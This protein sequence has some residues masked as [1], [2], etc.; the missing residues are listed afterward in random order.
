[1]RAINESNEPLRCPAAQEPLLEPCL[2]TNNPKELQERGSTK[3]FNQSDLSQVILEQDT[4]R[5]SVVLQLSDL[6]QDFQAKVSQTRCVIS[7]KA[8]KSGD[9]S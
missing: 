2:I 3:T 8:S 9:F 7:L 5:I 6:T 4:N 1:M